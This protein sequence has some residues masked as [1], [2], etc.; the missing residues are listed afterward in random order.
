MTVVGDTVG[1]HDTIYGCC[2]NPN[3]V[4]PYSARTKESC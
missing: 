2:S 1:C 4:L 3:N